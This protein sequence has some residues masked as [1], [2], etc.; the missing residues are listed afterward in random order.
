M[1][2]PTAAATS[3]D[4]LLETAPAVT[5]YIER[6]TAEFRR[7]AI[8]LFCAGFATFTLLYCV[9]PL[10]PAFS[11]EFGIGAAAASL[12]LSV[13]SIALAFGTLVASSLSEALGRKPVM[14]AAVFA[15]A[16][17]TLASAFAPGWESFLVL[18]AL[19]GLALAGLPAAAMAY[20]AEEVH[21]R[22]IGFAMGLYISGNALGGMAGRVGVGLVSDHA[23][24][25]MAMGVM[26]ALGLVSALVFA[27]NLRP[28]RH[29][30][31]RPLQLA[32]LAQGFVGHLKEPGL[33]LLF[34]EG[35]L[36]MGGLV[37]VYNYIG[38]RLAA[39]PLGLSQSWIGL[40][41]T[42]Y[43]VGIASSTFVGGLGDRLGRARLFWIALLIVLL[44]LG[45][46]LIASVPATVLGLAVV[47]FGFFAAH[48]MASAWVGRRALKAKAQ[49]SSLYL[50]ACYMGGS[51]LGS[52]GG[53]LLTDHG[54]LGVA[55][56]VGG[57]MLLALGIALRLARLKP[58]AQPVG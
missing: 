14:V 16:G 3:F 42:V 17:L 39:P 49:A 19:Q 57:G 37:T 35:F 41:F 34:L 58:V 55:G 2:P 13:P 15:S 46:T 54:W 29:F 50:F 47:T 20:L 44:G 6:G 40:I 38:Y 36:I 1:S 31:R 8:A 9:Q 7:T 52:A 12:S 23:S 43:I 30:T 26:G 10:L 27:L 21:P 51:L 5:P 45:L 56:L 24:W 22:A 32:G 11:R 4:A 48:S 18:R 25:H 28:S 33:R 53:W